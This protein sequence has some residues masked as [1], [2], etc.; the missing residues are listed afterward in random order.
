LRQW[1]LSV[2]R[3]TRDYGEGR[4]SEDSTP[5]ILVVCGLPG[6][7]KSRVSRLLGERLSATVHRTDVVR[8]EL[9][10][11]PEYTP[12]E[13]HR[14]YGTLRERARDTVQQGDLAILDGTYRSRPF[15][16]DVAQ[17]ASDIGADLQFLHVECDE[18]VVRDRIA[19]RT[20]GVSDAAFDEYL[21]L[22][23][24]FDTFV[25]SHMSVDNSG[26]WEDTREAVL[27]LFPTASALRA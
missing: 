27:D 2:R 18:Q 11:D 16:E 26:A 19:A 23:S 1:L 22:K 14:V 10:D 4:T 13:T 21:L 12:K 24:E 9:V 15:R 6:V 5:E 20:D 17:T 3:T 8:K 7:G 25:R